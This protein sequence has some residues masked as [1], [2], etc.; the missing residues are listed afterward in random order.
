MTTPSRD[1]LSATLRRDAP[2]ALPEP[3]AHLDGAIC[4]ALDA[5][6]AQARPEGTPRPSVTEA[7]RRRIGPLMVLL[8]GAAAALLVTLSL[9]SLNSDPVHQ[10]GSVAP[11]GLTLSLTLEHPSPELLKPLAS[12]V[13]ALNQPLLAEWEHLT[14]DATGTAD[15]LLAQVQRP[16]RGLRSLAKVPPLSP[17]QSTVDADG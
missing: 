6:Y 14:Q 13:A 2:G 11:H 17:G 10:P 9:N 1:P 3:P 8:S 16:L 12:L 4:R 5:A 7:G 15:Y